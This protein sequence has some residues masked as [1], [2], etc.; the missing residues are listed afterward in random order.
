MKFLSDGKEEF[1]T[2]DFVSEEGRS[3]Q[4][5]MICDYLLQ[6]VNRSTDNIKRKI[7]FWKTYHRQVKM[8]LNKLRMADINSFAKKFKS[9]KTKY[10][11]YYDTKSAMKLTKH[12]RLRQILP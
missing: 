12:F 3:K 6:S 10:M 9:G 11:Y 8:I 7:Y 2:P 1:A 4:T 5:V